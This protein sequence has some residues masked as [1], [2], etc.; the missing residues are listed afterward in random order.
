ME[1]SRLVDSSGGAESFRSHDALEQ[2]RRV[3]YEVYGLARFREP[4]YLRWFYFDNPIGPAIIVNRVDGDCC[5]AHIAGIP[6]TYHRA[7][8]E[9]PA[10]FP[11]NIAVL[12]KARGRGLMTEISQECLA[13]SERRYGDGWLG[14]M[15]NAASTPGY[16]GRLRFRLVR[17]LPVVACPP[18]W[19]SSQVDSH[20]ATPEFLDGRGF[21]E[22]TSALSFA[23]GASWSQRWSGELLRWRLA[24]P[25]ARYAVH[26]SQDV[27]AVTTVAHRGR[28]PV[29]V[30]LKIFAVGTRPPEPRSANTVIAAACRHHRSPVAIYAGFSAVARV[31]G[32][33]VPRRL[34]PAP[35]NLIVRSMRSG[36]ANADEF[37]FETM[38]LLDFDA[39]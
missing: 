29:T 3:L 34:R 30:V 35:L 15:P 18:I 1:D 6:Q 19:S 11:L 25:G 14:G 2:A 28:V 38:E 9:R 33:P 39:F 23:P 37:E 21:A 32:M 24:A 8:E 22:F 12:P 13:V 31:L 5:V 17:Q 4:S 7:G 20:D 27:A 10:V 16:T 36:A 26:R